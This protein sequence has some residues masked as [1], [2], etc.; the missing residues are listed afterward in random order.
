LGLPVHAIAVQRQGEPREEIKDGVNVVRIPALLT[1]NWASPSRWARKLT[2]LVR[3]A[4]RIRRERFDIVH[5]YSTIGAFILPLLVGRRCQWVQ[6]FQT[7]AV[8]S[9]WSLARWV[10]DRLR[11]WQGRAFD[12]NLAVTRVLGQ[13]LFGKSASETVDEVPAGV[14]LGLFRYGLP[15]DFRS[16]LGIP[17]NAIVFVHAGV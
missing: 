7:G 16:E 3:A 12:A 10:Q 1:T 8:S 2:F 14:N 17:S 11:A 4:G 5:V 6:E 9:R 13:R 15:R